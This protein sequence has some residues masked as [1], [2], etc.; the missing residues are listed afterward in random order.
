M[1]NKVLMQTAAISII[2]AAITSALVI[3]VYGGF[4]SPTEEE[5]IKEF[6]EIENA[7][8]ISPHG[9]RGKMDKGD[10]SFI[11]V[12][13]RSQEEYEKEHIIG[14]VSVPAYKDPRTSAYGDVERM[15]NSF[16][17]L[18]DENPGKDI[19]VYC[20]SMPCM[21]GR[22][23]GKMLAENGI[24]V[25]H[26]GIGWNEWRY[27]W[28]LWNHEFEWNETK[29]DDYIWSGADPGIPN[30]ES[31]STACPISGEFGC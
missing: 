25:K 7:V 16:K 1:E 8:Y 19:I 5:L 21:T 17:E 10:D 26:L 24:Y 2:A 27:Y 20:Y 31:K 11:L 9:L 28:T 22:K 12:D 18:I 15:I 6:Y 13:L 29:A 14:A 3:T 4:G 30:V 23:I